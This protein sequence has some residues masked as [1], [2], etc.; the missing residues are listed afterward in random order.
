M[1]R[2]GGGR[3]YFALP[4]PAPRGA[5]LYPFLSRATNCNTSQRITVLQT[6][7]S[8]FCPALALLTDTPFCL[9][10]L[11]VYSA[12]GAAAMICCVMQRLP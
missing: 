10:L 7:F 9:L 4:L 6:Y 11:L 3:Y 12:A 1:S 8:N 2:L 5:T